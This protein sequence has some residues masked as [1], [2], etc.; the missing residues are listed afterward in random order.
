VR[1]DED[2][3]DGFGCQGDQIRRGNRDLHVAEPA[4][5]PPA[6]GV[7]WRWGGEAGPMSDY[8]MLRTW[9]MV[10]YVLGYISLVVAGAGVVVWAID[11]EGVLRTL[12]VLMIGAPIVMLIATWP[13]ALG[14]LLRAVADIGDRVGAARGPDA[15]NIIG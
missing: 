11:V 9:S 14:Q 6:G 2:F 4:G 5:S 1:D 15:A 13:L 10:L 12:A 3:P 7:A 8:S